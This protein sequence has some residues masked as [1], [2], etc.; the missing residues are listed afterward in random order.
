MS[1][2]LSLELKPMQYPQMYATSTDCNGNTKDITTYNCIQ[3][4]HQNS[5]ELYSQFVAMLLL[6]GIFRPVAAA[7]CALPPDVLIYLR[8]W[9][10][11]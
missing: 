7:V 9:Y 11:C 8:H 5:L 3:R 10:W 4:A 2:T 6:A 1:V